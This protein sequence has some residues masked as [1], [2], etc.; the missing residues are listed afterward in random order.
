M[1]GTVIQAGH[2]QGPVTIHT[3]E[4][5]A[6][7]ADALAEVVR[8][9]WAD[10][11][12]VRLLRQP[13]PLRLRWSTTGR[14]VTGRPA[15]VLGAAVGG[16]PLRLR[17]HGFLEDVVELVVRLPH[18]QLVVLGEPG[19]GKTVLAILLTLGL[20]Q[21]RRRAGGP[22]PVMLALASWDPDAEHLD[23]WLNRRLVEEYPALGDVAA[24]LVAAGRV[25]PILDGLDEI[26]HARH[27]AAI[28]ALDR[29]GAG[30][31]PFAV[32][33]RS[34]EYEAA[35]AAGGRVLA[36]AAVVEIEP[37]GVEDA[38]AF[39][40]AGTVPGDGRW[41]PVYAHLRAHP[42]GPLAAALS[43]P[44][45][46]WL[47]RNA[48]LHPDTDPADLVGFTSAHA[49]ENHLLD[50]LIP[51]LYRRVPPGPTSRTSPRY[52]P[53]DAQ[54]W[55]T[56]LATH[57]HRQHTRDLAW[58]QLHHAVP[59]PVTGTIY[60][61]G[62]GLLTGLGVG[63]AG[64]AAGLAGGLPLLMTAFIA[65]LVP[66]VVF[67]LIVRFA[68]S[69]RHIP[70]RTVVR[71]YGRL[72][73]L[74]RTTGKRLPFGGCISVV[75]VLA[76]TWLTG[77]GTALL[78][79]AGSGFAAA[80]VAAVADWSTVPVDELSAPSPV[81]V[82]RADRSVARVRALTQ[83]IGLMAAVGVLVGVVFGDIAGLAAAAVA[84]SAGALAGGFDSAWGL[85]QVARAWL[86]MRGQLPRDC[87][88]FLEDAHRRGVLRQ[89]GAVYQF[90]HAR[91]QDRLVHNGDSDGATPS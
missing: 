21:H 38:I 74:A 54:R 27:A 19:A 84:A 73:Q 52:A 33:C 11:A 44:L 87:I 51:S 53:A 65:A 68:W 57:L 42:H 39:L 13:E 49:I 48:Y 58:W 85:F 3:T 60:G 4:T 43:T 80:V 30:G 36:T 62:A 20:L 66:S 91:L 90:R 75:V 55:L 45:A 14:P 28:E 37:V 64:D 71:L 46:V 35:V 78:L 1:V 22:V 6:D 12:A 15:A 17:L 8:R 81:S 32:T 88:R 34:S 72:R 86:A 61:L 31:R 41:N 83:G 77:F 59:P 9:Q 24:T 76:T 16:R 40:A 79:G 26:S 70:G 69:A 89:A 10:E 2:I 7:E 25:M 82:L 47:A 29:A 18:R 5:A 56:F 63:L 67:G 23:T 50:R